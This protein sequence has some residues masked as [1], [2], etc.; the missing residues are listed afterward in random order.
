M[1]DTTPNAAPNPL[2]QL[3]I[4]TADPVTGVPYSAQ[5]KIDLLMKVP[6]WRGKVLGGDPVAKAQLDRLN[7][8]AVG[9]PVAQP[10]P[11]STSTPARAAATHTPESI[12]ADVIQMRNSGMTAAVVSELLRAQGIDPS[13]VVGA[14]RTRPGDIRVPLEGVELTPETQ[15]SVADIQNWISAAGF[16]SDDGSRLVERAKKLDELSFESDEALSDAID[17]SHAA[18]RSA[19]GNAFQPV[20]DAADRLI[21]DIEA[22]RPG[23]RQYLQTRPHLLTDPL[24]VH[25]FLS[26]ARRRYG[27]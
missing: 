5:Q 19:L 14:G 15:Q 20:M 25:E 1:T 13:N 22:E 16:G 2:D 8:E 26:V 6:E 4:H 12:A 21:A 9:L 24:L 11:K 17:D 7:H 23:F 27:V 3:P 10:A 18:L